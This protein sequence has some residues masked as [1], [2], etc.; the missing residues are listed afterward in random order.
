MRCAAP[1]EKVAVRTRRRVVETRGRAAQKRRKAKSVATRKARQF[2][3]AKAT[4]REMNAQLELDYSCFISL[5]VRWGPLPAP[6]LLLSPYPGK[7]YLIRLL[8][9]VRTIRRA[10]K[11]S[12][13]IRM[14]S[15]AKAVAISTTLEAMSAG[16][17]IAMHRLKHRTL[18]RARWLGPLITRWRIHT[19]SSLR[20][21]SIWRK[22]AHRALH[23]HLLGWA[24]QHQRVKV[25]REKLMRRAVGLVGFRGTIHCIERWRELVGRRKRVRLLVRR[26]A[27]ETSKALQQWWEAVTAARLATVLQKGARRFL[28]MQYFHAVKRAAP[29]IQTTLRSFFAQ[30]DVMR[31]RRR[32]QLYASGEGKRRVERTRAEKERAAVRAADRAA[33]DRATRLVGSREG[34]WMVQALARKELVAAAGGGGYGG[35]AERRWAIVAAQRLLAQSAALVRFRSRWPPPIVCANI[36]CCRAFASADDARTHQCSSV[37]HFIEVDD[38]LSLVRTPAGGKVEGRRRGRGGTSA[39]VV[40]LDTDVDDYNGRSRGRDAE[41]GLTE[42]VVSAIERGA[43]GDLT[44]R[45]LRTLRRFVAGEPAAVAAGKPSWLRASTSDEDGKAM[46][47]LRSFQA[48][49]LAG[50]ID[51]ASA[52]R[53]QRLALAGVGKKKMEVSMMSSAAIVELRRCATRA[54]DAASGRDGCPPLTVIE[55]NAIRTAVIGGS[56]HAGAAGA[57]LGAGG[58]V[59]AGAKADAGALLAPTVLLRP[60]LDADAV[61]P[62]KTLLGDS[63]IGFEL[64]RVREQLRRWQELSKTSSHSTLRADALRELFAV[65][66]VNDAG[67]ILAREDLIAIVQHS[68]PFRPSQAALR[69]LLDRE[70][71]TFG[72]FAKWHAQ[73][74]RLPG[75]GRGRGAG[76]GRLGAELRDLAH[77]RCAHNATVAARLA[78]RIESRRRRVI[79]LGGRTGERHVTVTPLLLLTATNATVAER[80]SVAPQL[81]CEEL[82]TRRRQNRES[83]GASRSESRGGGGGGGSLGLAVLLQ[84]GLHTAAGVASPHVGTYAT[85]GNGLRAARLLERRR[86]ER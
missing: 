56:A 21:K 72:V 84:F 69:A 79:A 28:C 70:A 48:Q 67:Q 58:A 55:R 11:A 38:S 46:H 19:Q 34:K 23:I 75:K 35:A 22:H 44:M 4:T 14:R 12:V 59:G 1:E 29:I 45:A 43:R 26:Y 7:L 10:W 63:L 33:K 65:F 47:Q 31:L 2:M 5:V 73:C 9:A 77:R 71:I 20:F 64:N 83:R 68:L 36:C 62:S 32:L 51:Q 86:V 13:V 82:L 52:K 8:T 42:K 74:L 76:R 54:R 24:V 16:V 50:T 85:S 81:S 53:L 6:M 78:L 18:Q 15:I 25:R 57:A 17:P 40:P 60:A 49:R 61:V 30:R 3:E 37:P 39:T 41:H 66:D 27:T 80:A